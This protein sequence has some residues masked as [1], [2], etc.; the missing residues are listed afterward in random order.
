MLVAHPTGDT[1]GSDLQLLESVSG[2][3]DNGWRVVVALGDDGPLRTML[4]RRGAEVEVAPVPVV[5]RAAASPRGLLSLTVEAVRAMPRLVSGIR[6]VG[7]DAVYV[8]TVTLPVWLLAARLT[9]VP[10]LCHVHEAEADAPRPLRLA[11]NAPLLM[12]GRVLVNSRTS[13]EATCRDLPALRR[14]TSLV[15]NGVPEPDPGRGGEPVEGTGA[16]PDVVRLVTVGRLSPRKAPD[17]ALEAVAILRASGVDARLDVCGTAYPGYEDYEAGLRERAAFSD[18]A[19]SVTFRGY[20]SPVAPAVSDADIL[21]APSLREPFGNAVVEAQLV[22]RPVVA[23]AAAGHLETVEDG[24]TGLLVPPGDPEAVACAVLRL[25]RHPEL[26]RAVVAEGARSARER[27][28]VRRYR[29]E[30]VAAVWATA[31]ASPTKGAASR[32]PHEE[33][34]A[35]RGPGSREAV[36]PETSDERTALQ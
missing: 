28:S 29:R 11:L 13:F 26:R 16:A 27:F 33:R 20:V 36:G 1:Y 3:V 5:R 7:A 34:D 35:R 18:I 23:A 19:G 9:G 32:A 22:G 2:L 15:Y 10:A 24:R 12:A 31:A 25:V 8:N 30:V 17:V 21:L 4:A 6:S 14:R